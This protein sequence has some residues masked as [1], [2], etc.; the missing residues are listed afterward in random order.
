MS[1]CAVFSLLGVMTTD[2]R[3]IVLDFSLA[4]AVLGA[5][6]GIFWTTAAGLEPRNGGL[7]CAHL[8]TGGNGVGML[9]PLLTPVIGQAFG[10]DRAILVACAVCGIGAGLW[11][12]ITPAARRPYPEA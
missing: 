1:L 3:L 12:A 11:L 9:A 10:W 5:C 6:E 7:A 2:P 4:F 8:N